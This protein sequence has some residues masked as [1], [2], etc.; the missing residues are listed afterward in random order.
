MLRTCALEIRGNQDNHLPL[1]E[2]A[3][4]NSYQFSISAA[5]YKAL[6][7]R[8][9][10][11]LVYQKEIGDMKLIGPELIEETTSKIVLIKKNL[12]IGQ[13]RQKSYADN[14][15]RSLE[16]KTKGL[17][18]LKSVINEEPYEIWEERQIEPSLHWTIQNTGGN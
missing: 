2:F 9:C 3:Y 7:D 13:S 5:P 1:I 17:F 12:Q 10:R 16:F 6:Y 11:F 8:P 14:Y 15:R 18:V 4:N